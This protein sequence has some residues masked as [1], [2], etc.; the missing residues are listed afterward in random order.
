MASPCGAKP[1]GCSRL[2]V[3]CRKIND[4]APSPRPLPVIISIVGKA[5]DRSASASPRRVDQGRSWLATTSSRPRPSRRPRSPGNP[6]PSSTRRRGGTPRPQGPAPD[7][8]RCCAP[9]TSVQRK[10]TREQRLLKAAPT[11]TSCPPG[12][13]C[14]RQLDRSP[15]SSHLDDRL[16]R[17]R[18]AERCRGTDLSCRSNR[19]ARRPRPE[20]GMGARKVQS[21]G[22]S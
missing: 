12:S 20:A 15:S 2:G 18:R 9:T 16:R 21:P 6:R 13:R 8:R 7:A 22:R 10:P 17:T 14:T 1:Q 19:Q 11:G 4:R 3:A 5:I